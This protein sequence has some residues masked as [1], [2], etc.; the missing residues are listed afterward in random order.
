MKRFVLASAAALGVLAVS[1]PGHAAEKKI[2]RM[3]HQLPPKHHLSAIVDKWAAEIEKLSG[4]TIDVQV[5]GSNQLFKPKENYPA[6]AKGDAECALSVNFQ[7]GNT[8]PEMNATLRPYSV[9]D[10]NTLRNWST[11]KP[12]A[13]MDKMLSEK[14]VKNVMWLFVTNSAA[15]TSKGKALVAPADFKGVKIRG[16]NKLVDEGLR[17]MGAAP[18][19]MSGSEVYQALQTGVID[20]GL[21]DVSAAY[22]R[23]YYEVQDHAAISPL[24]SVF[25]H[26]YCNPAWLAS[27]TDA[28]RA[29]IAKASHDAEQGAIDAT[30]KS[31]AEAPEQLRSKGMKVTVLDAK[32]IAAMKAAMLPAFD[33]AFAE[34]AGERGQKL[35]AE[36]EAMGAK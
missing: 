15:I 25:F 32:Q 26:G 22:S 30:E 20:A 16:L 7:W 3:S 17:A 23:K 34:A 24:F 33:K 5:F 8:I 28:Q 11:S 13:S 27:L 1:L 12:A 14:G 9:S 31:A 10:I 18:A 19:V 35:L 29:A 2:L 4:D 21:T 6:V 36:I